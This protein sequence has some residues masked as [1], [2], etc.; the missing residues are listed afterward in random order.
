MTSGKPRRKV[1]AHL[2]A[3]EGK[4]SRAGAVVLADALAEDFVEKVEI[5][6]HVRRRYIAAT[7]L[8]HALS[9]DPF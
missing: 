6:A 5:L 1:E 7:G 8:R 3:E 2:M 4:R 9:V